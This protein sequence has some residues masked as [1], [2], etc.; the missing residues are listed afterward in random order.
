M[1]TSS[2]S[3]ELQAILNLLPGAYLLLS[4]QLRVELVS[5]GYQAAVAA[6][7]PRLQVGEHVPDV[8]AAA[9]AEQCPAHKL[10]AALAQVLL[11]GQPHEIACRRSCQLPSQV[12]ADPASAWQLVSQPVPD[13]AGRM[14][15]VLCQVRLGPAAQPAQED[16][17]A[18]EAGSEAS[19]VTVLAQLPVALCVL[20]GPHHT[21][22]LFNPLAAQVWGLPAAGALGRPFLELLPGTAVADYAA[23]C[24]GVWQSGQPVRWPEMPATGYAGAEP[25]TEVTYLSV[26]F[27]PFQP[28]RGAQGGILLL[29]QDVTPL[30]QA[31]QQ[32]QQLQAEL[33]AT[34]AG[35]A[36]Y[37]A[38]LL[39]ASPSS[40]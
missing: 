30:L 23:A 25:A 5:A 19:L 17:L 10:R 4:P 37:V 35:L 34:T 40:K 18:H 22:E 21:V 32:V 26:H 11:T 13:A 16:G 6:G 38:E 29:A 20:R 36:D 14:A 27:Q 7:W 39:R 12:P 1:V 33:A 31:H 9:P 2:F 28:H 3:P 24:A 15:H 8:L